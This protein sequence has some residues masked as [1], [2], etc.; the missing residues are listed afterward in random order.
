MAR[1]PSTRTAGRTVVVGTWLL[2]LAVAGRPSWAAVL[3][4]ALLVLVWASPYV[5]ATNRRSSARRTVAPP[6]PL[7]E[8]GN[9]GPGR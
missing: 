3:L 9:A 5:L 6:G 4:G 1:S 8:P 2:A 7:V